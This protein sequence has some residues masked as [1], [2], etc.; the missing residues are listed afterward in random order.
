M[1]FN[2]SSP[3]EVTVYVDDDYTVAGAVVI[4]DS[5]QAV[6]TSLGVDENVTLS[7]WAKLEDLTSIWEYIV[8][9][10]VQ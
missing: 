5:Y 1:K 3:A 6:S 7:A 2:E 9:V 4:T 10:E 8:Y